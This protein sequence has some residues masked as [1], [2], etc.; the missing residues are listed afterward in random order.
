ML[1]W[2]DVDKHSTNDDAVMDDCLVCIPYMGRYC[3]S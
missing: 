3:V 1:A 2:K